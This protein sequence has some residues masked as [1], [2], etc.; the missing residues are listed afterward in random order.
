LRVVLP[1][2]EDTLTLGEKQDLFTR[3]L[4]GGGLIAEVGAKC[5][6]ARLKECLR[7]DEQ[8]VI[9]AFGPDGRVALVDYLDDDDRWS[10]LA[11][12]V[13]NNPRGVRSPVMTLHRLGLAADVMLFRDGVPLVRS[14][15]Y[16][17]L[18]EWWEKQHE[19]CRWGGRFTRPDGNHFSLTHEGRS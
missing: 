18:G 19:L 6:T 5:L 3:L 10:G 8:A 2:Y 15:D 11:L 4:L 7:T 13:S 1:R 17:F 12:A 14:E 9:N 16:T